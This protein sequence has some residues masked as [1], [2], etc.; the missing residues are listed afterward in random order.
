[1]CS[2]QNLKI[3]KI[4]TVDNMIV[5]LRRHVKSNFILHLSQMFSI[6]N[7]T[8]FFFNTQHLYQY[9]YFIIQPI[10]SDYCPPSQSQV[11]STYASIHSDF[12]SP[13]PSIVIYRTLHV[14][15]DFYLYLGPQKVMFV[16]STNSERFLLLCDNSKLST[17]LIMSNFC[18]PRS[19][20]GNGVR[21]K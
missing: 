12:C 6:E 14:S 20:V 2:I 4:T 11:S 8:R 7:E 1:M 3:E 16:H 19:I 21:Y 9:V 15:S 5:V 17:I 10:L 13:S 18:F